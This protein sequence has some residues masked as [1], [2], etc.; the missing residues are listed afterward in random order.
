MT[1][2][3]QH[4][5]APWRIIDGNEIVSDGAENSFWTNNV[6]D[7]A[8]VCQ[9]WFDD[10]D[11]GALNFDNYEANARLIAAAPDL[12]AALEDAEEALWRLEANMA[13]HQIVQAAINKA[14]GE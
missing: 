10:D 1:N 11:N 14:K 9:L 13:T 12:L 3:P 5:P 2:K 6:G 8:I 4:T 7:P